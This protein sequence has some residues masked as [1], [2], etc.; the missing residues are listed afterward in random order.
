MFQRFVKCDQVDDVRFLL[1]FVV[2][3]AVFWDPFSGHYKPE[4]NDCM[5]IKG[6]HSSGEYW[7]QNCLV[8]ENVT[9][10]NDLQ[11]PLSNISRSCWYSTSNNSTTTK[12]CMIYPMVPFPVILSDTWPRFQGHGVIS[13]PIDAISVSCA[14]L[15]HD[16]LAIVKLLFLNSSYLAR[17][18]N[19]E[20][21]VV[22]D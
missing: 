14:Q 20:Y 17:A 2:W 4:I 11:W 1:N 21:G 9:T 5:L 18:W 19:S 13:M 15:T 8:F 3:V 10:F 16:L 22:R 7:K 6:I 12:S